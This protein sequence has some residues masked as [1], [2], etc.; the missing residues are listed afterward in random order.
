MKVD[1]ET[2]YGLGPKFPAIEGG[3]EVIEEIVQKLSDLL[4][5]EGLELNKFVKLQGVGE[6]NLKVTAAPSEIKIE[7][8]NPQPRLNLLGWLKS[9]ITGVLV[10]PKQI[11]IQINRFPD[12][13]VEVKS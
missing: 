7:V 4:S 12:L 6:L 2:S 5:T 3:R 11:V 10:S 9:S 13:T 1:Y 8:L